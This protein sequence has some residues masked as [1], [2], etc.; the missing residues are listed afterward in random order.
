MVYRFAF[1]LVLVV[2]FSAMYFLGF[3]ELFTFRMLGFF[4][5]VLI[6]A[7]C[8]LLLDDELKNYGLFLFFIG[9]VLMVI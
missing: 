3:L 5:F 2:I 7:I 8:I 4:L 9:I 1:P 6:G